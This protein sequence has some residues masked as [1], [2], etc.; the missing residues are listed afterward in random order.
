MI[1]EKRAFA[2]F[3]GQHFLVVTDF[4]A[5]RTIGDRRIRLNKRMTKTMFFSKKIFN[6]GQIFFNWRRGL[7]TSTSFAA[8][9]CAVEATEI[10]FRQYGRQELQSAYFFRASCFCA[11]TNRRNGGGALSYILS[12][13]Q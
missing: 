7:A 6:W 1:D 11:R 4:G 10:G 9:D 3:Y 13:P 12:S 8:A 2:S 5:N